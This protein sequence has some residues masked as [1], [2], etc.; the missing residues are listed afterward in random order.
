MGYAAGATGAVTAAALDA[1]AGD[2]LLFTD[3]ANPV[4]NSR[5][6][7]LGYEVVEDHVLMAFG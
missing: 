4:S 7:R 5:Y 1:G 3:L 2:V 6:Q